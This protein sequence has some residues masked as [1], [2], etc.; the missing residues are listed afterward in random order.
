MPEPAPAP[1]TVTPTQFE[2]RKSVLPHLDG[3]ARGIVSAVHDTLEAGR[4]QSQGT[5]GNRQG[6]LYR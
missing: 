6:N 2:K 4:D 5:G 3:F 1:T